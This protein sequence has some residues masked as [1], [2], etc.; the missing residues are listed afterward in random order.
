MTIWT[1]GGREAAM[2]V[3]CSTQF[4]PGAGIPARCPICADDRQYIPD[5]GQRWTTLGDEQGRHH[6]TFEDVDTNVEEIDEGVGEIVEV[7]GGEEIEGTT[8]AEQ[9]NGVEGEGRRRRGRRGRRG[10]RR[11]EQGGE[12]N[13]DDRGCDNHPWPPVA[14]NLYGCTI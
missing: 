13:R 10:G 8:P 9:A 12:Q 7:G 5:V 2:C 6:N 3:A 14:R 1:D 4:P 11:N